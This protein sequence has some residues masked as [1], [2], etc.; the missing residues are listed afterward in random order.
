MFHGELDAE[1]RAGLEVLRGRIHKAKVPSSCLDETL[2]IATWNIR[3]FG[4]RPRRAASLHYIAEILGQ[5]D[6]VSVVELRDDTREL[7][8]VL[9]YLGPYWDAVYSD[10]NTD[11]AGNRER[12]GFVYDRRAAV[13]TGLAGN[14]HAARRDS[15]TGEYDVPGPD[16]WRPPYVASFAQ[17]N[18]GRLGPEG[19]I[20]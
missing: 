11:R 3:E 18:P 7:E 1:T 12:V 15:G 16:W 9:R 14:V 13:F 5:F 20:S 8:T 2:T 17:T 19:R 6:L 10:Y 4:R